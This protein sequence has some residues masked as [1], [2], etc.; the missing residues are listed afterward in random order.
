MLDE[1][2]FPSRLLARSSQV[3]SLGF[4]CSVINVFLHVYYN[5]A[6]QKV[7]ERIPGQKIYRL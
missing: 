6:A 3:A 2:K 5:S 1:V 7:D 4:L